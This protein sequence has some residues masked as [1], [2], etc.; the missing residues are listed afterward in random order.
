MKFNIFL[1]EV[2]RRVVLATALAVHVQLVTRQM[3][4]SS[5][6]PCVVFTILQLW[7]AAK[8]LLYRFARQ[9]RCVRFHALLNVL[10]VEGGS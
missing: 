9:S 10:H 7:L 2:N 4:A 5:M 8:L 1:R 6:F 3:V